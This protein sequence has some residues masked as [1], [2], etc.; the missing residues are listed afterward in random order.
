MT[1]D[2]INTICSRACQLAIYTMTLS[3]KLNAEQREPTEREAAEACAQIKALAAVPTMGD[4]PP[5]SV[6]Q[7]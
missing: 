4:G 1:R 5:A 6:P 3:N 7:L 2:T